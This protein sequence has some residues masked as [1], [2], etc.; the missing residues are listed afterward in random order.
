MATNNIA[1][2][3]K[4]IADEKNLSMEAIIG[5]I[6]AALAAAY[7]KEFGNKNQNIKVVFNADNGQTAVFDVKTV[8]E[9]VD[10]E[11]E[12]RLVEEQ[13]EKKEAGDE[14]PE[15]DLIKRFNPRSEIM[16]SEVNQDKADYK[17]GDI[18]ETKLEVPDEYGRMAAQT[19]KQV[20]VQRLREAERDHIFNEYKDKE[21]ELVL[22]TIQRKEGRRFI[23]DLGK[24]NAILP[25]EEQIR[26]ERYNIGA[27]LN[28]YIV[29]VRVGNKGP[30]IVLSRTHP[31]IVHELFA[32]EVPEIAAGTV[33]IK[34]IAR[35]AGSRSKIAVIATEE[36][37]DPVGSCVGQRGSR[38]QTVINELGGEKID[39]IEWDEDVKHFITNALSPAEI[40]N[41]DI[42]EEEQTA[43]V[44][45][46]DDQL[47]LAIGRGGQ[48]VRLAAKLTNWKIDIISSETG[49]KI[50][51]DDK[52]KKE[53]KE[54]IEEVTDKKDEKNNKEEKSKKKT[55]KAKKEDKEVKSKKKTAKKDE[56]S[57]DEKPKKKAVKKKTSKAKK[58]DK[59]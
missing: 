57:E 6:E 34:S 17:I 11:E 5:A 55:S 37:I 56:E 59:E 3:I 48:N 50:S 4:Q 21:G 44:K 40:E 32:T 43:S 10:L 54:E 15:E 33:E 42:N 1:A 45:V 12:E 14:I 27:R 18:I 38:V 7:R 29:E 16:I 13:K 8:V 19:A 28:F 20:I 2:A 9:N 53:D 22:G 41:I 36:N 58:E 26:T 31:D 51:A 23:V 35:E 52:K 47:S 39:I 46:A 25:I 30:E 49:D 24:A